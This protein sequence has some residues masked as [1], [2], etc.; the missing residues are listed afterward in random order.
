MTSKLRS[1]KNLT[2]IKSE[3]M[4]EGLKGGRCHVL[5]RTS[6]KFDVRMGHSV[7]R[8]ALH[9]S[10]L[11]CCGTRWAHFCCRAIELAVPVV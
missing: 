9:S 11:C 5:F 2:L 7:W 3:N 1:W 8:C 4:A 10:C 6:C